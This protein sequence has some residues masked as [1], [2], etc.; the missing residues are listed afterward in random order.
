MGK[1]E[2]RHV[3]SKRESVVIKHSSNARKEYEILLSLDSPRIVKPYGLEGDR[4]FMPEYVEKAADGIAGY[5]SEREAWRFI[6]DVSEGLAYLHDKGIVHKD[7]KPSNILISSSGFVIS[8]FDCEGDVT[9]YAFTPP[10]WNSD[11][12]CMTPASDIWSLGA[13]V[14]NLLNG[15]YIFS[16][17]GGTVQRRETLIPRLS[18]RFS[19]ELS[20]VVSRCLSFE[21]TSRPSAAELV[22]VSQNMLDKA[23]YKPLR[24]NVSF[25]NIDEQEYVHEA[26]WPEEMN[27]IN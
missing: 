2:I 27:R 1:I 4:L 18:D 3:A 12:C 8:D 14:F 24:K 19:S 22:L 7:I 6:H 10:E 26:L 25:N 20:D 17:K 11:R 9:S 5:C 16:G 23:G 15:S 13:S 21:Q